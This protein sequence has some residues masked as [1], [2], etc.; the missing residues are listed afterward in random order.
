MYTKCS[1]KEAN[2]LANQSFQDVSVVIKMSNFDHD[3]R[4]YLGNVTNLYSLVGQLKH[5]SNNISWQYSCVHVVMCIVSPICQI[6]DLNNSGA[7][8]LKSHIM[9]VYFLSVWLSVEELRTYIMDTCCLFACYFG[10]AMLLF[11]IHS[12]SEDVIIQS[13]INRNVWTDNGLWSNLPGQ[14]VRYFEDIV[15]YVFVNEVLYVD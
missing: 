1:V 15:R 3:R 8:I 12:L 4:H 9:G 5:W 10:K 6:T 2:L 14:N 13:T 7:S 11:S